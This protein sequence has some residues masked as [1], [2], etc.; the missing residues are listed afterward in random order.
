[1]EKKYV[2]SRDGFIEYERPLSLEDAILWWNRT[3]RN[4]W[5]YQYDV[6]VY[7]TDENNKIVRRLSYDEVNREEV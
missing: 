3:I 1:M 5:L 6:S 2:V 4:R 7:E